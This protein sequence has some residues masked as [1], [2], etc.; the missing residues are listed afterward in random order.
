MKN[1]IQNTE[2][3][4]LIL[5]EEELNYEQNLNKYL[6]DNIHIILRIIEKFPRNKSNKETK[7]LENGVEILGT[8]YET[9]AK[10]ISKKFPNHSINSKNLGSM[11]TRTKEK[12]GI[13]ELPKNKNKD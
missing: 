1:E 3:K 6:E 5:I 4:D 2:D 11:I 9:I 8:A 10:V 7:T 12:M 13:K